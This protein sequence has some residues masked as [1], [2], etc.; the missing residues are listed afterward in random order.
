MYS[1]DT[2][3]RMLKI[4]LLASLTLN[5]QPII[6]VLMGI[7]SWSIRNRFLSLI[8]EW[9]PII[10]TTRYTDMSPAYTK[11]MRKWSPDY[12]RKNSKISRVGITSASNFSNFLWKL[13]SSHFLIAKVQMLHRPTLGL[14]I[15]V[16]ICCKWT[17]GW[18]PVSVIF[19]LS[20]ITSTGFRAVLMSFACPLLASVGL[21]LDLFGTLS[22]SRVLRDDWP[23]L[24]P[25]I[26]N[27]A[28]MRW[29]CLVNLRQIL[30]ALA[31]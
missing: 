15:Y 17:Q 26:Q 7:I 10:K 14:R 28:R 4:N 2:F 6:R 1:P 19:L 13:F 24:P 22:Q 27:E 31:G 9:T 8:P 30:L 21:Q 5:N 16:Y 18:L 3:F 12:R 29:Q 23:N 11:V 25:E 20:P